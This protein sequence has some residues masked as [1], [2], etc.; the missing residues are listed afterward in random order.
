M[1][2][3]YDGSHRVTKDIKVLMPARSG[4]CQMEV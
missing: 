1:T 3:I 4:R 2:V